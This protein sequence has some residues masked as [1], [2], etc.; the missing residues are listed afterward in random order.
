MSSSSTAPANPLYFVPAQS[1]WPIIT[2]IGL[3][4]LMFGGGHLIN[5]PDGLLKWSGLLG[6]LVI[7]W[8]FFGWFGAVVKESLSGLYS[9][10]MDRSFRWGMRW[11][12]F[13]EVMFFAAFFGALFY[14]R[15]LSIPWLGG[16]GAHQMTQILLWPDFV[17]HWPLINPPDEQAFAGPKAVIDPWHLPLVN[18][19]LLLTSSIT[20]TLA[21]H[22]LKKGH[23]AQL[24]SWLAIT[25]GL[26]VLFLVIQAE[27]Y[28]E[29]YTLLDLTLNSGVYGS[30]F[31]ILTGF[32][33]L[34][35]TLGGI[36]L[37]VML[38]RIIKGHFTMQHHFGFEAAAWY[39]HFVDVVWLGLFLFVYVL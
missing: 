31:F 10:Q 14:I 7:I 23:R 33:G 15:Q 5:H 34:H 18:T 35:V 9:P 24:A 2:A 38:I 28:I 37:L 19:V 36:I 13:S 27:E 11:F 32:H 20:L 21:H 4:L 25:I 39:W 22:A 12:I 16:D 30:T 26:G 6:F 3:F 8:I 1:H 17:A 29:A